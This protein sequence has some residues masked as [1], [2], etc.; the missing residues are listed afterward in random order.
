VVFRYSLKCTLC[1][2]VGYIQLTVHCT[3]IM[4]VVQLPSYPDQRQIMASQGFV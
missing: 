2:G 4:I 1:M 3:V